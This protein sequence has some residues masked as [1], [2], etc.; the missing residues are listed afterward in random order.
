MTVA[1]V[2]LQSWGRQEWVVELGSPLNVHNNLALLGVP[3]ET[4]KI[5]LEVW[6]AALLI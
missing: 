1:V 3:D 2:L 4:T 5:F 6:Y